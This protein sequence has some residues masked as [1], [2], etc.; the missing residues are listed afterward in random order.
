MGNDEFL[1]DPGNWPRFQSGDDLCGNQHNLFAVRGGEGRYWDIAAVLGLAEPGVSRGIA[2][3]DVDGDGRLDFAVANQWA[4]SS[5]YRNE[6]RAVGTFLGLHLLVARRHARIGADSIQARA[7]RRG[8]RRPTGLG[9]D[10]ERQSCPMAGALSPRSTAATAIPASEA[11]TCTLDWAKRG[12]T[13]PLRVALRWRDPRGPCTSR[14]ARTGARLAHGRARGHNR[15]NGLSD[16]ELQRFPDTG[17]VPD[18]LPA[19][20][21]FAAAITI[22]NVLGHFVLGFEQSWAQ[23]LVALGT[24]YSVELTLEVVSAWAERRRPAFRRWDGRA[25]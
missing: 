21:R 16:D 15:D 12:S 13:T 10:R 5:F 1:S 19:L 14:D 23:P 8:L 2:T 24:A 20:R 6:S 4:S 17:D 7:P 22:L 18:R 9:G 11:T 25:G 3:A